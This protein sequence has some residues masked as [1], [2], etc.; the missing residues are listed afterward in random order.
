MKMLFEQVK[1]KKAEV[2]I[3]YRLN[4]EEHFNELTN[5]TFTTLHRNTGECWS[6]W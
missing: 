3:V 5:S 1:R 2:K 4:E 6:T